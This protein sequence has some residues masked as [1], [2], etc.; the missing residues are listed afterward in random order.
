MQNNTKTIQN[1]KIE[2]KLQNEK[3]TQNEY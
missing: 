3:Q 1:H 2:K